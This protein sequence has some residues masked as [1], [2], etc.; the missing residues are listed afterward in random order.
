MQISDILKEGFIN[1]FIDLTIWQMALV[2]LVSIICGAIICAVYRI[3]YRG[4]MF[5]CSF[6]L[7]L[8]AMNMITTL[9]ILSIRTN[10]YLSLGTLGALSVVRFRTAVKEPM[11]TAFIFLSVCSGVVCGGNLLGIALFGVLLISVLL[12]FVSMVQKPCGK[13]ILMISTE[14]AVEAAAIDEI[15]R[16]TKSA[17]LKSKA[18]SGA[19]SEMAFEVSLDKDSTAFM[20]ELGAKKGVLSVSI[21]KSNNEYI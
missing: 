10:V 19:T 18:I 21:V 12:A 8:F 7:S 15:N 20:N 11:D 17:R 2:M 5:S 1:N 13:Y 14:S 3:T 4:V 6:C 16:N 9:L